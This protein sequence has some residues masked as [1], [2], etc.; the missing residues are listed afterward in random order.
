M[1]K[2]YSH[3]S[4]ASAAVAGEN[5]VVVVEWGPPCGIVMQTGFGPGRVK[6]FFD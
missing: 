6:A 3:P 1:D 5:A 4:N 2:E